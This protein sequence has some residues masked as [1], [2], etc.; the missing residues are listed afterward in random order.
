MYIHLRFTGYSVR[1]CV[2]EKF[3]WYYLVNIEGIDAVDHMGHTQWNLV[4]FKIKRR[5]DTTNMLE[6]FHLEIGNRHIYFVC[7]PENEAINVVFSC[8]AKLFTDDLPWA[9]LKASCQR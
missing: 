4:Y 2:V 7:D 1:H 3:I 5:L 8:D 6:H 9:D